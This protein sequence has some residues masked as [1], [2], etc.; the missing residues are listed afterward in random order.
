MTTAT[1]TTAPPHQSDRLI[2]RLGQA[3]KESASPALLRQF[4]A[5]EQKYGYVPN[6]LTGYAVNEASLKRL[7]AIYG[8]LWDDS[9]DH[10]LS[11]EERELIS[12]VVAHENGCGYC[13][14]NHR[15]GLANVIGDKDRAARIADDHH[16]VEFSDRDQALVDL[17]VKVTHDANHVGEADY[18]VLRAV[19]LTNPGIVE[20]IEVAAFFSFANRLSQAIGL[21]PD[22]ELF[23]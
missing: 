3:T 10:H 4:E 13:V 6:W 14:A 16:L 2:T 11:I 17:A 19:G 18:A 15:Y 9:S 1:I 23:R 7:L 20:A 12:V 5:A 8:P 22:A 21:Q